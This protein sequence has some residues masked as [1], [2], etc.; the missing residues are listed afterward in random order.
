M[1][2]S[3]IESSTAATAPAAE[4]SP[5][6][7]ILAIVGVVVA[8]IALIVL[9]CGTTTVEKLEVPISDQIWNT[10][11]TKGDLATADK[12]YYVYTDLVCPYC[13]AFE[14][15]LVENEE[16]FEAFLA[17]NNVV[18]EARITDFLYEH[19]THN[20]ISSQYGAEALYCAEKQDRFWD[21]YDAAIVAIWNDFF[22]NGL[23][24]SAFDQITKQYLID[25]ADS[26]DEPLTSDFADCLN[27]DE[28]LSEV[29][30]QTQKAYSTGLAGLPSMN[31]NGFEP[32]GFDLSW[33]W[34]YANYYLQ[35]GLNQ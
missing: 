17:E 34:E 8:V 14:N 23:D 9:A 27:N 30:A 29:Q 4:G 21:Y 5:A 15:Q 31:F 35:Q 11:M 3:T 19:G 18:Y 6:K 10:S 1:E 12:Y 26:L 24:E 2:N 20:P 28:T 32:A 7:R 22:I 13:V 33:G 25:I 16:E